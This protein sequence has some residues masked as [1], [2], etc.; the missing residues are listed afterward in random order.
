MPASSLFTTR[1]LVF[2]VAVVAGSPYPSSAQLWTGFF[3]ATSCNATGCCCFTTLD[4]TENVLN[5]SLVLT[6]AV[7]GA[8]SSLYPP[9]TI[10]TVNFPLPTGFSFFCTAN[11]DNQTWT[12]SQDN[13]TIT[14]VDYTNPECNSIAIRY[15]P[16]SADSSSGGGPY[17]V[18]Q[19][20]VAAALLWGM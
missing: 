2:V 8:C 16:S 4:L 1:L 14:T 11:G 15:I 5:N 12:L 19:L 13:S 3:N 17:W 20:A 6:S 10:A 7:N 18:V 9:N